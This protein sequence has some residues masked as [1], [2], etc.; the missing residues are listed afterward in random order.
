M[1][2]RHASAPNPIYE[3][4]GFSRRWKAAIFVDVR[5]A[6]ALLV[7]GTMLHLAMASADFAC[8]QHAVVA[9]AT[10][11]MP[12]HQPPPHPTQSHGEGTGDCHT[13]VSPNCCT[14]ITSCSVTLAPV[15]VA[16]AAELAHSAIAPPPEPNTTGAWRSLAPETPPP[17]A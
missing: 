2:T 17:R 7:V 12:N 9:A 16:A 4:D 15:V 6:L 8:A 14:A 1:T 11:S 10:P 3:R 13:P 5:R